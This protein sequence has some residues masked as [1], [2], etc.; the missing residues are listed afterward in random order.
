MHALASVSGRR[1]AHPAD[2]EQPG[3]AV[4]HPRA[5]TQPGAPA[6]Q[7][8]LSRVPAQFGPAAL[9][10]LFLSGFSALRGGP[11][12]HPQLVGSSARTVVRNWVI[13]SKNI[14]S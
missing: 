5:G 11:R 13:I 14:D 6:A 12:R 1:P 4:T 9:G 2:A 10:H 3:A 7:P 8:E